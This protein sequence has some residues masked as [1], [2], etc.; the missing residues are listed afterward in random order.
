MQ[1][2]EQ[3][4]SALAIES[5]LLDDE[6]EDID[7]DVIQ[8]T[9][10]MLLLVNTEDEES[11]LEVQILTDDG[12][13]YTHHDIMLPDFPLCMAWMDCP[14]FVKSDGQQQTIGNYVAVGTFAPAIEIWNLDV[15]DPIEPS[16]V[17]G[18]VETSQSGKPS[19]K[20]KGKAVKYLPGSH[21]DSVLCLSWN[22][23]YRQAL[24]SGSADHTVK[25]WDVTNQTCSYTFSHHTD[26]V[27][28]VTWHP[29]EAWLLTSGGFDKTVQ[30]VDC[31]SAA[32]TCACTLTSD[33]EQL[34]WDPFHNYCLYG[35][36]ED[37]QVLCIDVRKCSSNSSNNASNNNAVLFS[38]QAHNKTTSSLSF[39]SSVPGMLA[40]ASLDKTVKVWDLKDV[41]SGC[42]NTDSQG[43][44][45]SDPAKCIA[46]KT[47]NVGKLF[48]LR[49]HPNDPYLLA[50]A[51]DK[52]VVAVW[53]SD[54]MDI[55]K[56]HF[57]DR[58][59]SMPN[60]YAGLHE[61]GEEFLERK[62]ETNEAPSLLATETVRKLEL[63]IKPA[64]V[65]NSWMEDNSGV[66]TGSEKNEKDK[67]K[68]NTKK[69]KSK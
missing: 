3:G 33:I 65:D 18:G 15:L 54:E 7:D 26:K 60:P 49:F 67:K 69:N 2:L 16:A 42:G 36:L 53:E 31:R 1:I 40:T 57:Q 8:P 30:L 59:V 62:I 21:T 14:P 48:T 25:V 63:E 46:Y 41:Y 19:K 37:G 66:V 24:A 47:M 39:S 29:E 35:A 9:D 6:D 27:Q 64:V 58:E 51:G 13:L 50:T 28:A 52:G 38:F 4:G 22:A 23:S 5:N 17:L 43:K 10:S 45:T 44:F 55:I 12:T 32:T 34:V 56:A 20:K 11:H 68:K 61:E